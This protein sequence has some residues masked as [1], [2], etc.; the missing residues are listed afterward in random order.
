MNLILFQI[1]GFTEEIAFKYHFIVIVI[2]TLLL[3]S[4][5]EERILIFLRGTEVPDQ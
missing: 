3:G 1:G 4:R 5:A 2:Q